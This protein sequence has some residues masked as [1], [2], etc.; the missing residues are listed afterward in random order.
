MAFV[1]F[2]KGRAIQVLF[3]Y[4]Y[5]MY[6]IGIANFVFSMNHSKFTLALWH[7]YEQLSED[8]FLDEFPVE[9]IDPG[10][11]KVDNHRIV[12]PNGARVELTAMECAIY[13][14]FLRH[15]GGFR[16]DMRWQYYSELLKIY[17]RESESSDI[18]WKEKRVDDL[19]E[20]DSALFS[21]HISHIRRKLQ[22]VLNPVDVERFCIKRHAG[23]IYRIGA[24]RR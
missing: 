10:E 12:F 2:R 17:G 16:L 11:I 14:L 9:Y 19:C 15:P 23:G 22:T 1:I 18:D 21:S 13:R 8:G 4:E 24:L 5:M 6:S 7:F 20:D 3:H